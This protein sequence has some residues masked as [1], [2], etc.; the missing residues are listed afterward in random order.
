MGEIAQVDLYEFHHLQFDTRE[1]MS[2]FQATPNARLPFVAH[3]PG[4]FLHF[5]AQNNQW[6]VRWFK[7]CTRLPTFDHSTLPLVHH[8]NDQI[9]VLKTSLEHQAL[10]SRRLPLNPICQSCV[11]VDGSRRRDPRSPTR[12]S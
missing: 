10:P 11:L 1:Q 9:T 5:H 3:I 7:K 6:Q 4:P 12:K 8:T 2:S